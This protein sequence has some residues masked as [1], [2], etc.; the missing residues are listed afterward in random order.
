MKLLRRD[1]SI[2]SLYPGLLGEE[3]EFSHNLR[4]F[5]VCTLRRR[6]F[7]NPMGEAA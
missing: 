5:F 7:D 2:A 6:G 3:R 4:A 1:V